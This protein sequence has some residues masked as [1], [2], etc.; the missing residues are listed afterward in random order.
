MIKEMTKGERRTVTKFAWFPTRLT[1]SRLI[2][3]NF[4][5]ELQECQLVYTCVRDLGWPDMGEWDWEL[6]WVTICKTESI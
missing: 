3:L 2:W 6:D 1:H 4:Y 5:S